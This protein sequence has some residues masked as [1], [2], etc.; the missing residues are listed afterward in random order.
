MKVKEL[1]ETLR[2]MNPEFDVVLAKDAEGN[3][4]AKLQ[5]VESLHFHASDREVQ[6]PSDERPI[7]AA[8]LWP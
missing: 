1:M 4:F 7:N 6:A 2:S 3:G 5:A 8:V